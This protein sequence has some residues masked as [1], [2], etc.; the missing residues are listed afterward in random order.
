MVESIIG[1][2]WSLHVL[3][4]IRRGVHRP[5]ALVRSDPG[6]TTKVL[7]ERLKKMVRFGI[8]DRVVYPEA[9]PRVEY[10]FTRFGKKFTRV[11]DQVE[12]LQREL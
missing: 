11:I 7:N 4:Q 12:Q 1:C 8:L 9:P 10:K 5:G 6:L 2:K 3:T